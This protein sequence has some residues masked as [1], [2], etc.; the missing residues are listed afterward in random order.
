ML[1]GFTVRMKR[2]R[3]VLIV[4]DIGSVPLTQTAQIRVGSNRPFGT[5]RVGAARQDRV[6][7]AF[8][9]TI[10]VDR[11]LRVAGWFS[12]QNTRLEFQG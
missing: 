12:L 3:L 4:V 5:G 10:K 2:L 6:T 7:S 1:L 8:W 9:L 11:P